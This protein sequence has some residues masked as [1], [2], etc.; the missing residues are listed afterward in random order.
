MWPSGISPWRSASRSPRSPC[1][2]QLV[3]TVL[4]GYLFYTVPHLMFHVRHLA[5]FSPGETTAE[6][7]VLSMT[8]ALPVAL[9]ALTRKP[10]SASLT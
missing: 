2:G 5:G 10:R 6:T 8:V 4:A 3:R 9:L 1:T 7:I